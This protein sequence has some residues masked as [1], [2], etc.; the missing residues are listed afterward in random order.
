MITISNALKELGFDGGWK[1]KGGK[2]TKWYSEKEQPSDK[3]IQT[4]LTELQADYE[5]KQYQRDRASAYP[6]TADQL[7]L[8]YHQGI[9][10]WK[11]E[12]KKV[13]DQFPKPE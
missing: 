11:A 2:I 6:S 8:L 5:S 13:K 3:V 10:G 4:K 9:D 1:I 7:D 12:I